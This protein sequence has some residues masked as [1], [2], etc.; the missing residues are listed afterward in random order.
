VVDIGGYSFR[1]ESYPS[2]FPFSSFHPIETTFT[3]FITIIKSNIIEHLVL[4]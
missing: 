1:H 4:P 3:N 2:F